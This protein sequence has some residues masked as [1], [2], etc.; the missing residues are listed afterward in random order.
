MKRFFR[1]GGALLLALMLLIPAATPAEAADANADFTYWT[2]GEAVPLSAGVLAD[3]LGQ[4]FS[5]VLFTLPGSSAGTLYY[6]YTDSDV[7]ES[8]VASGT[9]YYANGA[10]SVDKVAFVPAAGYVGTVSITFRAYD[11]LGSPL[12][13]S[14][15]RVSVTDSGSGAGP[16][17][18]GDIHYSVRAGRSVSFLNSDFSGRCVNETGSS[19]SYI[20]FPTLPPYSQGTLYYGS[21][22]V[23]SNEVSANRTYSSPGSIRFVADP[24]YSGTVVIPFIGYSV[25]GG[26]FDGTVQI[27]VSGGGN[28]N[29]LLR[30]TVDPGRRVY[31]LAED[32]ADASYAATGYDINYIRFDSLPAV[33]QGVI[34]S[35]TGTAVSAH[36][37]YYKYS[38]NNL[39]FYAAGSFSGSLSIPFTGYA[40]NGGRSFSGTVTI[41]AT[42]YSQSAAPVSTTASTLIYT[43]TGVAVSFDRQDLLNAAASTGLASPSTIRLTAPAEGAG[44][45]CLDFTS[46]SHYSAFDPAYSYPF[47]EVSR[48]S[49]LPKAGF[50]G[51]AVVNYTVSGANGSTCSGSVNFIV[52]PPTE[53]SYF[54]DMGDCVWAVPAVDF[55]YHYGAVNGTG[56]SAFGPFT[57]MRRGD[58]VLLLSRAFGFPAA[59]ADPSIADVPVNSYYASA[60]ASARDLGV[61]SGSTE[62]RF[63]PEKSISREDAAVMIYRCLQRSGSIA[64]GSYADLAGFPDSGNTSPYAVEGMGALVRLGVFNGDAGRLRPRMPL[65]RAE[66]ITILY[67]AL[68]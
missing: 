30:Y 27:T 20:R 61:I 40:V 45:L 39:N 41:S 48:I 53:S 25:N 44:R 51:V 49:Y 60:I 66:T 35:G 9:Q 4:S 36:S 37:S 24:A 6:N 12:G 68:T 5:Y 55:F 32:F 50:R 58:F 56:R 1:K 7:Y 54:Y 3:C 15:F 28:G 65:S 34:Y 57:E 16:R 33:S 64:P 22:N 29:G 18:G 10:P 8:T 21:V 43:T 11:R 26:F 19:L 67:R 59:A 17:Q 62:T 47:S 23:G 38:L 63:E 31:F 2:A 14:T 42:G 46:L 13:S 52:S